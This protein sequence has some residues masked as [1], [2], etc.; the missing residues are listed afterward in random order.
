MKKFEPTGYLTDGW[1]SVLFQRAPQDGL[2][3]AVCET[4]APE[5]AALEQARI[6]AK[7]T[8]YQDDPDV[9]LV[10]QDCYAVAYMRTHRLLRDKVLSYADEYERDFCIF[11]DTMHAVWARM[12]STSP[13]PRN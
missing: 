5:F 8:K 12:T 1:D 6:S 4:I 10:A 2:I 7:N 13:Y 11:S 9:Y 3:A